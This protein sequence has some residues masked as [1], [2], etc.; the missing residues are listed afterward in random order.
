MNK[1]YAGFGR[2]NITPMMGIPVSG[3]FIPRYADGVLDELEINALAL[4]C[5]DTKV[6]LLSADNVGI[7]QEISER[8]RRH[9]AEVCDIPFEASQAL[10]RRFRNSFSTSK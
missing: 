6:V 1:L 4:A 9:I 10:R 7:K 8:F 3:Y 5:G 2:V